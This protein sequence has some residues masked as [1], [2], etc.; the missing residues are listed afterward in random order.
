L[1][2]YSQMNDG[3]TPFLDFNAKDETDN[4]HFIKLGILFCNPWQLPSA[5]EY[6]NLL[7]PPQ[8][9]FGSNDSNPKVDEMD[10][11]D[12]EDQGR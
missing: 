6:T 8:Q 1:D 10:E 4:N 2:H 9:H 11:E 3:F 7:Q 5:E 12:S